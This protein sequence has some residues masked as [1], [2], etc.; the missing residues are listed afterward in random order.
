MCT[1][2]RGSSVSEGRG[3]HAINAINQSMNQDIHSL[4]PA[5]RGPSPQPHAA[6]SCGH[7]CR[8]CCLRSAAGCNSGRGT[9]PLHV[10]AH[11][12][13]A[14]VALPHQPSTARLRGPPR[15][16]P[17]D[18]PREGGGAD[19]GD[20]GGGL[21]QGLQFWRR[22]LPV[23][24]GL[25]RKPPQPRGWP[26]PHRPDHPPTLCL[27]GAAV[28][29]DTAV[30]GARRLCRPALHK[31]PAPDRLHGTPP[32]G[33]MLIISC[34]VHRQHQGCAVLGGLRRRRAPA[35]L[36]ACAASLAASAHRH[37]RVR[38][39]AAAGMP[40]FWGTATTACASC[41]P[42]WGGRQTWRLWW[43]Q[44]ARASTRSMLR[45]RRRPRRAAPRISS[46]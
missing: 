35:E 12:Q 25:H 34:R 28:S 16:P 39:A 5:V 46:D 15:P 31:T 11:D 27:K 24:P 1:P 4:E 20:G 9:T 33:V 43:W 21:H 2:L 17:A 44:G 26:P 22:Q 40:C 23:R 3:S 30:G 41:A 6:C 38:P 45:Q 13:V 37:A 8:C 36:H 42:C 29:G 18:Q 14:D 7:S 10:S 19:A 32:P